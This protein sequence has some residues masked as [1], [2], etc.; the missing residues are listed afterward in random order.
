MSRR[1]SI[2]WPESRRHRSAKES[3]ETSASTLRTTLGLVVGTNVQAFDADLNA[4]AAL[5]G[6]DTMYYRSAANTW[7]AVSIGSGLDFTGGTLT[8]SGDGLGDFSTNSSSSV[9]GEIV[10][11]SGTGGKTGKRATTTGI[12]K[13]TNG[14]L[15]AAVANSDYLAPS[16]IGTTVQAFSTNLSTYAS[17]APSANVQSL[18]GAADYS[19]IR[20]LLGLVIGT[21]IQAFDADL[22][23]W[24]GVTPGTGVA[25]AAANAVNGSGGLITYGGIDTNTKLRAITAGLGAAVIGG[26]S[27]SPTTTNPLTLTAADCYGFVRFYGATGTINLPPGVEGMNGIIYNTGAF[28][29]TIDPS[30]SEVVERD[31]TVQSGGVSFTLSSGRGNYV[32][33]VFDGTRWVTV[34]YKGTLAAGS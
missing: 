25:A 22:S 1:R 21:N 12:A 2:I 23:I 16:A 28:T 5:S 18:M 30:G 19:A 17:I 27:A 33:L 10:L 20:T 34:G 9:D 8:A 3:A 31:G 11:Y 4:L 6:T 15:S 24:A 13:L 29:I 14:V 32:A 26:T 7:S